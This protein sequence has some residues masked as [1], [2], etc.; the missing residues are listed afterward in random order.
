MTG[1]NEVFEDD[2]AS[3]RKP[4]GRTSDSSLPVFVIVMMIFDLVACAVRLFGIGY[5]A[6]LASGLLRPPGVPAL[7][8]WQMIAGIVLG[9]LILATALPA[10]IAILRK[11]PVGLSL[12]WLAAATQGLCLLLSGIFQF[13]SLDQQMAAIPQQPGLDPEM[14]RGLVLVSL[15]GGL[16]FQIIYLSMYCVATF[17]YGRWLKPEPGDAA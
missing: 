14:F 8:G 4:K 9:I 11:N 3:A 5:L 17:L 10:A 15:I 13:Q 1:S 16:C 2:F 7:P 6:L 12:G